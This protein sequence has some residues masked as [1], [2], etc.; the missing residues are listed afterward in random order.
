MNVANDESEPFAAASTPFR[1]GGGESLS[2]ERLKFVGA[3]LGTWFGDWFGEPGFHDPGLVIGPKRVYQYCPVQYRLSAN[4]NWSRLTGS[5]CLDR[6]PTHVIV[7][8]CMSL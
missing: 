1:P 7:S 2:S 6:L 3:A 5:K 4:G 8:H